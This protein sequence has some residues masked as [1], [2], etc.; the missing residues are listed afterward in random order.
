MATPRRLHLVA[1]TVVLVAA[2]AVG[3]VVSM[4]SGDRQV[5]GAQAGAGAG[6]QSAPGL[7][8]VS[9]TDCGSAWAPGPAGAQEITLHNSDFHA[10][11]VRVVGMGAGNSRQVFA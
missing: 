7:V 8:D 10:G 3:L 6:D 11:A 1:T 9:V 5:A 2:T 4:A